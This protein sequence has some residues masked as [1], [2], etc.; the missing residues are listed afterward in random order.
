MLATRASSTSG[1]SGF[2]ALRSW[3][4]QQDVAQPCI[5]ITPTA[6]HG[7]FGHGCELVGVTVRHL[8]SRLRTGGAAGVA[9]RRETPPV[10]SRDGVWVEIG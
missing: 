8:Q 2:W 7:A 4:L 3:L 9:I 10:R 5:T 6:S 1:P